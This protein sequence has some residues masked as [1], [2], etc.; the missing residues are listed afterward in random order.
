MGTVFVRA[1][2]RLARFAKNVFGELYL[3]IHRACRVE[4]VIDWR[5]AQLEFEC[6]YLGLFQTITTEAGLAEPEVRSCAE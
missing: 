5:V 3:L 2:C 1:L 4:G 6:L